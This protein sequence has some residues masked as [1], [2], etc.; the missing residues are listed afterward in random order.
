V[1]VRANASLSHEPHLPRGGAR[2]EHEEQHGAERCAG[3]VSGALCLGGFHEN[4][5][6]SKHPEFVLVYILEKTGNIVYPEPRGLHGF[7]GQSSGRGA[8]LLDLAAV[9]REA[10]FLQL[11]PSTGLPLFP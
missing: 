1:H 2:T 3:L 8:L 10:A 6:R 4:R 5:G 7:W 11:S 9:R